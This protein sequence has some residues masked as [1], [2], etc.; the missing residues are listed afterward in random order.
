M[1][2]IGLDPGISGAICFFKNGEVK[3]ILDIPNMAE[4]KINKRQINGHQINNEI[5]KRI[6]S[7]Y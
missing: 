2:I 5:T 1:L 6:C 4:G 7:S 3:E